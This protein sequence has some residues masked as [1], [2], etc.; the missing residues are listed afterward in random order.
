MGGKEGRAVSL[1]EGQ[2][3]GHGHRG[4]E[5]GLRRRVGR[6]EEA[7]C[8]STPKARNSRDTCQG[9]VGGLRV[10]TKWSKDPAAPRALPAANP[11]TVRKM[12]DPMPRNK[13][14]IWHAERGCCRAAF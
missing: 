10:L 8:Q 12:S 3:A 6:V 4:K 2:G 1:G 11:R 9:L 5:K 14:G 13:H 7:E